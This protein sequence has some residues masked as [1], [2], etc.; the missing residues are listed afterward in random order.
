MAKLWICRFGTP[1]TITTDQGWQFKLDLFNKLAEFLGTRKNRTTRHQTQANGRVERWHRMLKVAIMVHTSVNQV[2]VLLMIMLGLR[3]TIISSPN[4]S[5]AQ[6]VYGQALKLPGDFCGGVKPDKNIADPTSLV[7]NLAT[8]IGTYI[9][10]TK[11]H[12][13]SHVYI[14]S[15]L[16]SAKQIFVRASY[17]QTRDHF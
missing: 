17:R 2:P 7:K 1:V 14:P 9:E 16:Q 11:R 15:I 6:L 5:P 10:T 8:A 3:T 4:I 13:A 12:G